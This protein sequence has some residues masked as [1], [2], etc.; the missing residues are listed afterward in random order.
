M[1]YHEYVVLKYLSPQYNYGDAIDA[2]PKIRHYQR[3]QN[4]NPLSS[5]KLKLKLKMY[6][7]NPY[8]FYIHIKCNFIS[9]IKQNN[10]G[11][12]DMH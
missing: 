2:H 6:L 9:D 3:L 4:D 11:L 5:C 10:I 12:G 8:L 7:F 1:G